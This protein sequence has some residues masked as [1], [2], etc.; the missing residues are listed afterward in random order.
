MSF[1]KEIARRLIYLVK[2]KPYKIKLY[3]TASSLKNIRAKSEKEFFFGYY[4]RCPERNGKVIFHEMN[5]GFVKIIINDLDTGSEIVIGESRAFNW[6][7]GSR[8]L[9]VDDDTITF[10]DFDGDKYVSR[11]YSVAEGKIVKTMPCPTMDIF[12]KDYLLAPNFQRLRTVNYDYAYLT[13][14]ELSAT[15]FD[16]YH[17]DGVW[18]YNI[19]KNEKNLLVSL[20]DILKCDSPQLHKEGKH[21]VNHIVICPDGSKFMFIHR[22]IFD[23]KKYDRL[24]LYDFNTLKCL[25]DDPVQSHFCWLDNSTIMGYCEYNKKIG[26]HQVDVLTGNVTKLD[27][28]TKTHPDN[29]HPTP[30]GKWI[31]IDSYP[32]LDR[33]QSL[34]AY[35]RETK[36]VKKICDVFHDMSHHHYNRCD[37]HPRFTDNGKRI[38]FDSIYS[39]KRQLCSINIKLD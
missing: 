30:F 7:M 15:D 34:I 22:Y 1:Q 39:G 17:D 33:M 20:D 11:W 21:C 14:P 9:W 13:L 10:N 35:H 18:M 37:L 8:T 16:N 23:G 32:G 25:L 36:E 4:D 3:E 19:K 38:Y 26:W 29:G 2:R 24:M 27:E 6:Q 31:V 5:D 28:L 12:G